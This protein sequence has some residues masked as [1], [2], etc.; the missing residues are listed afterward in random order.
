MKVIIRESA[1]ADLER[2]YAWIVQD[3]PRNAIS[4]VRRIDAAIEDKLAFFPFMGRGGKAPGTRSGSF[5]A[6]HMSSCTG[7]MRNSTN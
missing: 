4:V 2:I 5:M 3:S 7:S 6:S 1:Y